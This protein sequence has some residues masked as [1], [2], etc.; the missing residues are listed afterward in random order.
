MKKIIINKLTKLAFAILAII[1]ISNTASAQTNFSGTWGRNDELTDGDHLSINSI[2]VK[3]DISQD[4]KA[5]KI[6]RTTRSSTGETKTYTE[7]LNFDGS[8]AEVLTPSKLKRSATAKWSADKTSLT[9]SFTAKDEQGNVVQSGTLVFSLGNGG[10]QLQLK[11]T[12][13]YEDHGEVQLVEVF[14]KQ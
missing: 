10:K 2:P 8:A 12:Q 1:S 9:E 5:L 6:T 3:L 14:D 4:D 13:S 7:T 11:G